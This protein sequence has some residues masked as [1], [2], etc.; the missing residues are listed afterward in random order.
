MDRKHC[1][2]QTDVTALLFVT[3]CVRCSGWRVTRS[4]VAQASFWATPSIEAYESHFLP[5]EETGPEELSALI[6]RLFRC[7]QEWEQ[8][9][10]NV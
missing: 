7:A 10:R 4:S 6:E 2:H 8:D 3:W 5:A 1:S 9:A